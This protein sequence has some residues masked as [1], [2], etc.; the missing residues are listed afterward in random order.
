[1][2]DHI[3]KLRGNMRAALQRLQRKATSGSPASAPPRAH[4]H[5]ATPGLQVGAAHAPNQQPAALVQPREA[6]SDENAA[7]LSATHAVPTGQPTS[8]HPQQP[9]AARLSPTATVPA[10]EKPPAQGTVQAQHTQ[11]VPSVSLA[12]GSGPPKALDLSEL[13]AILINAGLSQAAQAVQ[14]GAAQHS[15]SAAA[16]VPQQGQVPQP[17][18]RSITH[19]SGPGSSAAA[20][21]AGAASQAPVMPPAQKA[22]AAGPSLS[23]TSPG[24]GAAA[25]AAIDK[26]CAEDT[27]MLSSML[28]PQRSIRHDCTGTYHV[29][30]HAA[31]SVHPERCRGESP[32]PTA[33][34]CT[35]LAAPLTNEIVASGLSLLCL[36]SMTFLG[37]TGKLAGALLG[38]KTAEGRHETLL[39]MLRTN[40]AASL[41][42]VLLL[43]P[44]P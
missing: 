15:A 7:S 39:A 31:L 5:H 27:A 24:A 17:A 18:L 38:M 6:Q 3:G 41:M 36:Q 28:D 20:P 43:V 4:A 12:A 37:R 44:S 16:A 11:A 10:Q 35:K 29:R 26:A 32:V 40:P 9:G 13:Q 34:W 23:A 30:D 8:A 19:S 25:L 42:P 2:R 33:M 21:A 22:S 1:M 14:V